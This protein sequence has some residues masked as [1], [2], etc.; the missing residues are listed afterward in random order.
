MKKKQIRK[1]KFTKDLICQDVSILCPGSDNQKCYR[2]YGE[3]SK[4]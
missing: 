4:W 3:M 2:N 1:E